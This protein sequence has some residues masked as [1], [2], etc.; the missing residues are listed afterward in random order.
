M[1]EDNPCPKYCRAIQVPYAIKEKIEKEL[2]RLKRSRNHKASHLFRM[3]CT[4][5]EERSNGKVSV[6]HYKV[7]VNAVL[8]LDNHPKPKREIC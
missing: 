4:N 3:G 5:S 1:V 6:C 2:K 7:T 8:K